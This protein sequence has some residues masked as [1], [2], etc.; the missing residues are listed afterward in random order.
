MGIIEMI[1][2]NVNDAHDLRVSLSKSYDEVIVVHDT[3]GYHI[4]AE[5]DSV[6]KNK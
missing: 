5:L 4:V 6:I 1:V 3:E 2:K